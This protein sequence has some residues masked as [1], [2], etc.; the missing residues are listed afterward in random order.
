MT[1]DEALK[2]AL[3][4]ASISAL[5]SIINIIVNIIHNYKTAER[6]ALYKNKIDSREKFINNL[7]SY[8]GK[9]QQCYCY[10]VAA[11]TSGYKSNFELASEHL[12]ETIKLGYM[13]KLESN[14]STNQLLSEKI[15]EINETCATFDLSKLNKIDI[16]K[17]YNLGY[18][19]LKAIDAEIKKT[20]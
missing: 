19:E 1:F 20:G 13:V 18:V 7:A 6:I 8:I 11:R 4:P 5:L 15:D 10:A 16:E 2:I 14:P 9:V 12:S 3:V 17:L